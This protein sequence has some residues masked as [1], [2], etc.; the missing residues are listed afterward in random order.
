MARISYDGQSFILDDRRLWLVSGAIHYARVAPQ[1]WRRR[2][3][4]ARLAG[5]GHIGPARGGHAVVADEF[6]LVELDVIAGGQGGVVAGVQR[7][8]QVLQHGAGQVEV[9][10][11]DEDQVHVL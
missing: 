2:I 10:V 1:L 4:A 9:A 8:V 7:A 3:R 6:A 11:A 5:L